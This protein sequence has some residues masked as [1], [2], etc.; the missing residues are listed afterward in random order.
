MFSWRD[1]HTRLRSLVGWRT[2]S[3]ETVSV[4]KLDWVIT[5]RLAYEALSALGQLRPILLYVEEDENQA[6]SD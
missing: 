1:I 2:R 6:F 5:A 4:V 3:A